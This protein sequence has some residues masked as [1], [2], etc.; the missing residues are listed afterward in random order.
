MQRGAIGLTDSIIHSPIGE[1]LNI[2]DP[3]EQ[4]LRDAVYDEDPEL[5][6]MYTA[7]RWLARGGNHKLA[8]IMVARVRRW[9]MTPQK[10]RDLTRAYW[11][12]MG[13][14]HDHIYHEAR[15]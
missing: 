13:Q 9:M 8:D 1:A 2:A 12:M 14:K 3:D 7:S 4:I 10:C 11:D 15:L 6:S 5:Y